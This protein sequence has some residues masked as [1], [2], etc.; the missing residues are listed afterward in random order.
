MA[1]M[2]AWGVTV[3]TL[4]A[5]PV[6]QA[7]V[8]FDEDVGCLFRRMAPCASMSARRAIT[9]RSGGG[10]STRKGTRPRTC[11]RSTRNTFARVEI[12]YTFY[13]MPTAK[14][15]EAWLAQAPGGFTLRAEGA[16]ADHPPE[17][18]GRLCRHA[19][20]FFVRARA[21]SGRTWARCCFNCRRTQV[22]SRSA[23]GVPRA[24]AAGRSGGV[25]VSP[26]V[27]ADRRGLCGLLRAHGVAMCI[28]D[29]G[30]KTTPLEA[31]ARHGYFRLRDEGYTPA[32]ID[33]WAERVMSCASPVGRRLRVSSSTRT[34]GRA[35]SLPA[36]FVARLRR[37]V[38]CWHEATREIHGLPLGPVA[39]LAVHVAHE[40]A[41][42]AVVARRA[43]A[44]V[45]SREGPRR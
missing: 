8:D 39:V 24:P 14:T 17:A 26:R 34:R 13:R 45:R 5:A 19:R 43:Y 16:Q 3:L 33:Q 32:D 4:A 6:A 20:T 2:A 15:T 21:C 35:P 18:P 42:S 12:N 40:G 44:H 22:R 9:I 10:T 25:R 23:G 1:A 37:A 28:A 36:A 11:S 27:V 41:V 31:T 38:A 7:R 30:D 29:F